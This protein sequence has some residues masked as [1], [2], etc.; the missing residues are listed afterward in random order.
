MASLFE[1]MQDWCRDHTEEVTGCVYFAECALV[2]YGIG[3]I[4]YALGVNKGICW[5]CNT[6][7]VLCPEEV[8]AMAPKVKAAAA[9]MRLKI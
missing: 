6:L 3:K 2:G 1:S 4:I 8:A 5:T 7:E 9:A